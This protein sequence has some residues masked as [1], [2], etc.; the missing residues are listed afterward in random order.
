VREPN[1]GPPGAVENDARAL[2][3]R[4]HSR[5]VTQAS[6]QDESALCSFLGPSSREGWTG[7]LGRVSLEP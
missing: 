4:E 7:L 2:I 5:T 1:D 3:F 6:H